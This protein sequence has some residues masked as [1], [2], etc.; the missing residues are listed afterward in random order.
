MPY[1]AKRAYISAIITT[2]DGER[3]EKEVVIEFK[4]QDGT[5]SANSKDMTRMGYSVVVFN[6]CLARIEYQGFQYHAICKPTDTPPPIPEQQYQQQNKQG[7]QQPI[8]LA[9]F[10]GDAPSGA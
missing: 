6:S 9:G 4:T 5:V 7:Q 3:V 8:N 10:G 2:V 1:D